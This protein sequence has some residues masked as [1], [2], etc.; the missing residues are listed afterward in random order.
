[1]A[2]AENVEGVGGLD[3]ANAV[4]LRC[5]ANIDVF[6]GGWVDYGLREG[7]RG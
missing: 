6:L 2:W 7:C 5:A 4:G 1:M 3:L